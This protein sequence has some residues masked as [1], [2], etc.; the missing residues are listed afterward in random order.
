[1]SSEQTLSCYTEGK[2]ALKTFSSL[3]LAFGRGTASN[4]KWG[5]DRGTAKML[6]PWVWRASHTMRRGL[7]ALAP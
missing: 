2:S 7:L 6:A 4:T 1:M 3:G 5:G